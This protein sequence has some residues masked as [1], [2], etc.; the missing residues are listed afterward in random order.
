MTNNRAPRI[1][2]AGAV[3]LLAAVATV[4]PAAA[5][6]YDDAVG[7][8]PPVAPTGA[9]PSS[10]A[11]TSS[12]PLNAPLSMVPEG[13]SKLALAPGFLVHLDVLDDPDYTGNFRVDQQGNIMLPVLGAVHVA[14]ETTE[15]ARAAI[16]R[17]L[18]DGEILK[19]PQVDVTVLEYVAPQVTILGEV[20]APGRY[21]LLAPTRLND[22]LALA[23]G[24][25]ATAGNQI[26]ITGDGEK[27]MEVRLLGPGN[28]RRVTNDVMVHP[29]ETIHV[30]RAGIVYVMGAVTHPGGY[31]MVE[32][33]NLSAMQAVSMAGGTSVVASLNKIYLLRRNPQG[34]QE[35]IT[36]PFKKMQ[37][38]KAGDMQLQASDILYVPDNAFK[39]A[40]V[41]WQGVVASVASAGVYAGI[42]Y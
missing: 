14:G 2:I 33:G 12:A 31:V 19:D 16:A 34:G 4:Q 7:A 25:T 32:G 28:A 10:R 27:A 21:P 24:P 5:Q 23:G 18:L 41:N 9:P 40:M 3:L 37:H 20:T 42:L 26:V 38:G 39:S 8:I 30:Q 29:G 17:K 36:L 11:A 35:Q 22:V 15:A 6:Q 1:L 13:F